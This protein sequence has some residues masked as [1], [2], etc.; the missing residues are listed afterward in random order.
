MA[1]AADLGTNTMAGC[2]LG[3]VGCGSYRDTVGV[4]SVS[5]PFFY[6]LGSDLSG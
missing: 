6:M 3:R 5:P 2:R 4:P 1:Q